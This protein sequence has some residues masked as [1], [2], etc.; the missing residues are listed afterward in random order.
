MCPFAYYA[1]L[2]IGH[3]SKNPLFAQGPTVRKKRRQVAK[4]H[5]RQQ[6]QAYTATR[7]NETTADSKPRAHS[8][9]GSAI[10]AAAGSRQPAAGSLLAIATI[11]GFLLHFAGDVSQTNYLT[12]LGL[13]PTSFPQPVD[14]KVIHGVYVVVS[15][16]SELFKDVPWP[17]VATLLLLATGFLVI[18]GA[19]QSLTQ[20]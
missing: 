8:G 4:G 5:L 12:Q 15:E 1:R 18:T 16:G 7:T 9:L 10:A 13:E 20:G 17:K 19:Q 14:A 11:L 6:G 3:T 2:R